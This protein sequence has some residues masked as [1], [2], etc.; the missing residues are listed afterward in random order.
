MLIKPLNTTVEG[1]IGF[2]NIYVLILVAS[3]GEYALIDRVYSLYQELS[4][5]E[6]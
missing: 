4:D 3:I 6:I 2:C 5:Y 1:F